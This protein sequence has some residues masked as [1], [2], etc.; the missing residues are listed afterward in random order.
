VRNIHLAYLNEKKLIKATIT[1]NSNKGKHG[2]G[3]TLEKKYNKTTSTGSDGSKTTTI[4]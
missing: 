1:E 3:A 4:I 2:I